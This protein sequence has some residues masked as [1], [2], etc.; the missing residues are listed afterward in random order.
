MKDVTVNFSVCRRCVEELLAGDPE[1]DMMLRRFDVMW[2]KGFMICPDD[3]HVAEDA[4]RT[5][6]PVPD[7]CRYRMENAVLAQPNETDQTD[8]H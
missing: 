6:S 8:L 1:S 5:T 3:Y 4:L 7:N 2:E